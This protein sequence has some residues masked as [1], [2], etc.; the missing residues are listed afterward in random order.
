MPR[1]PAAARRAARPTPA[2]P[3]PVARTRGTGGPAAD[4]PEAA[5]DAALDVQDRSGLS[6]W[7]RTLH[8]TLA[9]ALALALLLVGL[10]GFAALT[11]LHAALRPATATDEASAVCAYLRTHD[12]DALAAEMDPAPAGASTSAFDRASFAA[13]L[14]ALD[15]REG[16]VRACSLRLLGAGPDG[17]SVVFALTVRRARV[18]DPFGSLVVVERLPNDR[19]TISRAST[20]YDSPE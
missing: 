12:Y 2:T 13:Q 20:F 3:G 10:A 17:A 18:A 11:V 4:A 15:Q 1:T 14:R 5:A 9:L 6:H 19:W 7:R 16:P 8:L